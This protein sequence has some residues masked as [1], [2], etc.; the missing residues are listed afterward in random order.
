MLAGLPWCV[1]GA[2]YELGPRGR[3]LRYRRQL[4][5]LVAVPLR[6][7]PKPRQAVRVLGRLPLQRDAFQSRL[8]EGAVYPDREKTSSTL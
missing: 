5:E 2:S 3:P 1:E 6:E 7:G 4:R 8:L